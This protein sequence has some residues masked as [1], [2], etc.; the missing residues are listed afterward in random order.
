MRLINVHTLD[1]EEFFGYYI[2]RYTIL[3]H[4]WG[5]EEI[6]FQE[7][8]WLRAQEK[9]WAEDSDD[10]DEMTSK[11]RRRL[12]DKVQALRSRAGFQ[13]IEKFVQLAAQGSHP[14]VWV[15]TCCIDKSSSAE[16]SEAIN[17]MFAWY[18][19]AELCFVYLSDVHETIH[20][21]GP[22]SEFGR[23]RWFTRGWTL[24]ELLAPSHVYFYN[25]RW[26]CFGSL[27]QHTAL[28]SAMTGIQEDFLGVGL[29]GSWLKR[30]SL[31]EKMSWAAR[32][33]TTR[34]EDEAY[35]LLGIFNV[36]MPLLYGEGARAFERLQHEIL[37]RT[38]DLS[39]LAWGRLG[40]GLESEPCSSLLAP[41][42]RGFL[43]GDR[44]WEKLI[45][46]ET[47]QQQ[48]FQMTNKGL[49]LFLHLWCVE[50]PAEFNVNRVVWYAILPCEEESII[51]GKR[52]ILMLVGSHVQMDDVRDPSKIVAFTRVGT[53]YLQLARPPKPNF[54][55]FP[56]MVYLS[57]HGIPPSEG[58]DYLKLRWD[59]KMNLS[60]VEIFPH[61][62]S[63]PQP[64]FN[65]MIVEGLVVPLQIGRTFFLMYPHASNGLIDVKKRLLKPFIVVVTFRVLKGNFLDVEL[66]SWKSE[67]RSL[68]Y[69]F[70]N[71]LESPEM[72]YWKKPGDL[73]V[74]VKTDLIS[75][76]NSRPI[77][78]IRL[79]F[80]S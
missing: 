25:S 19:Q 47:Q 42:P 36:Q 41:S 48:H 28:I 35:C 27:R 57:Q 24:Q 65:P 12:Q 76:S 16:L 61:T 64:W 54:N 59:R 66:A 3:S 56:R 10:L 30:P 26:D 9:E 73:G 4:T 39:L 33:R 50:L 43:V 13:K 69:L 67:D 70:L 34:A 58:P 72:D 74:D 46:P 23:S 20:E 53:T 31:A 11:R 38:E 68:A 37:M 79:N 75:Y 63:Q 5:K 55:F 62:V 6:S 21:F 78:D 60:C 22:G 15:D 7:Y 52:Q 1:L 14:Y 71:R 2:P 44:K 17:S 45:P 29:S 32:R 8:T 49:H 77:G 18:G 80:S 51:D 40:V